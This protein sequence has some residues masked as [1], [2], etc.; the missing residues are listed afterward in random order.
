MFDD[1]Q[2]RVLYDMLKHYLINPVELIGGKYIKIQLNEEVVYITL[3][4]T[5]CFE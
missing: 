2:F 5:Y 1:E 4:R 3:V